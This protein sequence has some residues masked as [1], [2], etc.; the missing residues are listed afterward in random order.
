MKV[1]SYIFIFF[2][3]TS[4]KTSNSSYIDYAFERNNNIYYHVFNSNNLFVINNA[5]DPALSSNGLKLAY[6]KEFHTQGNSTSDTINVFDFNS[7]RTYKLTTKNRYNHSPKWSPNGSFLGFTSITN[8]FNWLSD[9]KTFSIND[10][11]S[12]WL[13][14]FSGIVQKSY[15]M[16]KITKGNWITIPLTLYFSEDK[17]VIYFNAYNNTAT[18]K[19]PPDGPCSIYQYSLLTDSLIKLT[20]NELQCRGN[21]VTNGQQIYVSAYTACNKY[22][23]S[24]F[25]VDNLHTK[26]VI[27]NAEN[28]TVAKK[29]SL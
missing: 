18:C 12:L 27:K 11:D 17:K 4:Y 28:I 19:R 16:N 13:I 2:I 14:D 9:N 24:I 20:G 10:L 23:I 21:F 8:N 15:S 25:K 7:N 6:R 1:L 3:L 22:N 29:N 26:E 5:S